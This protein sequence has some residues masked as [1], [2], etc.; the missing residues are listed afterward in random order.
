M[1]TTRA[2]LTELFHELRASFD[3]VVVTA[4]PIMTSYKSLELTTVADFCTLVLRAE[5]TR[6]QVA[7]SVLAQAEDIGGT[8]DALGMTG[9]R[10]HIP[11]W[12]YGLVLG[13]GS[14]A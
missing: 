1:T 9:R 13:R 12:I 3:Y 8:I 7:S 10:M 5:A 2:H 14:T 4:P 6:V 11:A